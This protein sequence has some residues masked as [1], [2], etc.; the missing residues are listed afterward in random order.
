MKSGWAGWGGLGSRDGDGDGDGDEPV[1]VRSKTS[2]VP[3]VAP[4]RFLREHS[5][6]F[7][8]SNKSECTAKKTQKDGRVMSRDSEIGMLFQKAYKVLRYSC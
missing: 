7:L 2:I 4:Y 3:I 1:K 5:L 6:C 8:V